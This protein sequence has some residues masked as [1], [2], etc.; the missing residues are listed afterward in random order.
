MLREWAERSY[1]VQR[2]TVMEQGGHFPEWE[3][4]DEVAADIRQQF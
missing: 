4:P 3:V 1:N 2:R